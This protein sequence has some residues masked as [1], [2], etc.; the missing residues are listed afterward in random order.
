M[1]PSLQDLT[2]TSGITGFIVQEVSDILSFYN[3]N[4]GLSDDS[5]E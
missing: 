5:G 4:K 1:Q 2:G 3:D